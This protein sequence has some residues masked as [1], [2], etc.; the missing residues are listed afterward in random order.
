MAMINCQLMP[1]L[2]SYV[3]DSDNGKFF[4]SKGRV[5]FPEPRG[6]EINMMPFIMGDYSTIPEIYQHYRPLIDLCLQD[7]HDL[8]RC[9]QELGKIGYLTIHESLVMAGETQRRPG[10][11]TDG[12]FNANW[13]GGQDWPRADDYAIFTR[14]GCEGFPSKVLT[15]K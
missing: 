1:M 6:I 11:H 14:K 5:T 7:T 3:P 12:H 15:I 8:D 9:S 13:G 4:G 2:K 10:L